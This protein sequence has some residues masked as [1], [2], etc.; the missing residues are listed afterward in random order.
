MKSWL[1]QKLGAV[2]IEIYMHER[3][4]SDLYK[5]LHAKELMECH[6]L[7]ELLDNAIEGKRVMYKGVR[8]KA[9]PECT[10]KRDARGRFADE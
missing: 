1:I 8:I 2:R 9:V 10:R 7:L 4:V 3:Q 5:E 6:E